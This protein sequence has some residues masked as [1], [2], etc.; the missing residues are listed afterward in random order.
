VTHLAQVAALADTH[1]VV[2]K[3]VRKNVTTASATVLDDE[4]RTSEIARML[5]G[6][7]TVAAL[8]HAAD[9]LRRSPSATRTREG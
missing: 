4:A 2:T 5:S 1:A 8:E 7:D 6:E 9:L 3:D